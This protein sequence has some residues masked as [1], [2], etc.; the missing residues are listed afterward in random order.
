MTRRVWGTCSCTPS[1][2]GSPAG[3]GTAPWRFVTGAR[4]AAMA[5]TVA[6]ASRAAA[7]W[8]AAPETDA[9]ES[10]GTIRLAAPVDRAEAARVLLARARET[11]EVRWD[12][13][14][15]QGVRSSARDGSSSPSDP[16]AIP[17]RAP[18]RFS[19][20]SRG[21]HRHAPVGPVREQAPGKDALLRSPTG[22]Q[23]TGRPLRRGARSP[24]RGLAHGQP[25]LFRRPGSHLPAPGGRPRGAA[26]DS[27]APD[28]AARA[29]CRGSREP[30]AATGQ[31][32]SD[33][34]LHGLADGGST[35]PGGVRAF[36]ESP[37]LRIASRVPSPVPRGKSRCR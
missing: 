9:G 7:E 32:P 11:E 16:P 20:G 33:R 26:R 3:S 2:T 23:G 6:A 12:G 21:R 15:P 22:R 8:I 10:I 19:R 27:R 35:D 31:F 17:G 30:A 37:G 28:H 4:G 1:P 25:R 29:G 36:R 13:L 34:L 5:S 24:R 14:V 18:R